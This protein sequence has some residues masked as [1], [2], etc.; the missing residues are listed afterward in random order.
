MKLKIPPVLQFLIFA[1]LM[2]LT[3]RFT[4]VKH[5]EFKYQEIV[6]WLFFSIG[7]FTGMIAVYSFRKAS[8]T[9]DPMNPEKAS[10]LVTNSIYKFT[11]NP[12]YLGLLI[13]LI[14]YAIRL[15]NFYAGAILPLYTAYITIFQ[16]IPEEKT[17]STLFKEDFTNYKNTVRRWI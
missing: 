9:V 12:M 17:L 10:K 16:I 1:L 15:G 3:H 6:S 4:K 7:V 13:V 2:W 14:A 8:T 5:L 11:R